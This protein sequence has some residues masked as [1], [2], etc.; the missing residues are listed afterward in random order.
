MV[1]VGFRIE[2]GSFFEY[3]MKNREQDG[4]LWIK[5]VNFAMLMS[6]D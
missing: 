4:V 5:M 2:D 1:I 3:E 6:C